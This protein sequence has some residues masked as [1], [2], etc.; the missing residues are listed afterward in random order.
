M[1]G[2]SFGIKFRQGIG[3]IVGPLF[4]LV[5]GP[6]LTLLSFPLL[7]LLPKSLGSCCGRHAIR[8]AFRT[9]V[10]LL[11]FTRVLEIEFR[12][13]ENLD[14]LKGR[15]Y[16]LAP[17]HT[18]L[19]DAV[20]L[21]AR[22]NNVACILKHSILYNPFLGGTA[23]LSRYISNQS[24]TTMLR[25][26]EEEIR[27]G[28]ALLLFPEGTRTV[29][30]ARWINEF[31]GSAALLAKRCSA[32]LLPVYMRT[33]TRYLEKGWPVWRFPPMP[34]RIEIHFAPPLHIGSE[35][36]P[37]EF[38]QRLH[39]MYEKELASPH[40]LRRKPVGITSPEQ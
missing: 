34:I 8:W 1:N 27:R 14:S 16:I 11:Q 35:E 31:K 32:P 36:S 28:S 4:W 25:G 23:R 9:F 22:V 30:H 2:S 18:A 10:R 5:M 19:W 33:S 21:I 15:G 26:A 17:N 3:I 13:I 6:L 12:G 20:F 40:P 39:E 38:T 7:L 29:P 37:A 24:A